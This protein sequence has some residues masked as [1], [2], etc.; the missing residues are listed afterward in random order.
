M[1][2]YRITA[3]DGGAYEITAPD[4]ATPDQVQ[5]YVQQN[6]GSMRPQPAAPKGIAAQGGVVGGVKMGLRDPVDAGAQLLTRVL[7][8]SWVRAGNRLNNALA[9]AGLPLARLPDA[10]QDQPEQALDKLIQGANQQYEADRAA[11]GREGFDFAR[12]TGNVVN[13]VNA[14]PAGSAIKGAQTA[15]Q[16]AMAG[17]KAGA[18]G[19]ALQPVINDTDNFW[20]AKTAQAGLGAASG[21]LLT[22]ALANGGEAAIRG[23]QN[24]AQRVRPGAVTI[25]G[26]P[27][28][29][30]Q[31]DVAVNRVLQS[32]GM[33]LE[34]APKVILDSVRRQVGEAMQ[35][36]AKLNPSAA[37]RKAQAEAIGLT[38]DAA[39]TAGQL[40]R[41]PIRLAQEKNLSGIV[42]NTPEGP[43]NPLA[44]RMQAQAQALQRVFDNQGASSA[45]P[46][47]SAGQP[48]M[49][50]LRRADA[51][52]K[53]GVDAL[54]DAA[55]SMNAGRAAELDRA[56]FNQT[57]NTALDEGMWG[58]FL[59][60]EARG[61]I[62]DIADGKVPFTVESSVMI[63]SRLSELQRAA[64]RQG[65]SAAASALG[66][67]RKQL[68]DVPFAQSM[69]EVRAP[70]V[71]EAAQ[72]A[73][74][75]DNGIDDVMFREI[76]QPSLPAPP[77]REVSTGAE[78]DMP[79]GAQPG[80]AMTRVAPPAAQRAT[81][82]EEA[83]RA[84]EEA[85]RAARARFATIEDTPALKAALDDE[86]PADFVRKYIIG[87]KPEDLQALRQ[88]LGNSP[89]AMG[90]VRSQIAAHLKRAA[91]GD[92]LS[93]DGGFAPARLATA[94]RNIGPER[95]GAFFGPEE[96]MR[97]N[98]AAKVASD[99]ES[100]PAGARYAI[101]RSATGNAVF[102]LLQRILETPVARSIPGVRSLGN[103]VGEIANER[104]VQQAL[105]PASAAT[106][107]A[108]QL[109]PEAVRALHRLFAP[110]AV[111]AGAAAGSGF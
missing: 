109:S 44:S 38:G 99:L 15:R 79:P 69:P 58:R 63:D 55:R 47:T 35:Q 81:P 26:A 53:A 52:P 19:G 14:L 104:A 75:V 49:E 90:Q 28:T 92:N 83:R 48:I 78:F 68:Q 74:F 72:A 67:V 102:N 64:Q 54:Y 27:M 6:I 100:A 76:T 34:E 25:N 30:E 59:P 97:F 110:A 1:A 10:P 29:V 111:G 22:P 2:K 107:E 16:L 11:A 60:A 7:P 3:P 98:L 70:G 45:V 41:D 46:P 89:E 82:G 61:F 23:V 66:V 101:N 91:F 57:V 24:V 31:L 50:A 62:N 71:A 87:G 108:T 86:S 13:P 33:K 4:D 40:T 56:A 77:G 32:Q 93:G 51:G 95:L 12:L 65:N 103:Q 20:G 94:I 43:G 80:T 37:L 17:A 8:D 21:A 85:R 88:V 42:L 9:D 18:I 84:F 105:Q 106:K 5:A 73:G 96:V 39:L 36:R